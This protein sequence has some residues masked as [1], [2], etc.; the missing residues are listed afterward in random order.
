VAETAPAEAEPEAEESAHA[1]PSVVTIA[2]DAAPAEGP[3]G[4]D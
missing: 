3:Q 2:A 4:P 1:A